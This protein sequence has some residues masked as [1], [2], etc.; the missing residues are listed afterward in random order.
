MEM[1]AQV[2]EFFSFYNKGASNQIASRGIF[3][4]HRRCFFMYLFLLILIL[5]QVLIAK[6]VVTY[7]SKF[8]VVIM[9]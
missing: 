4:M 5:K 3:I 6:T 8:Y 1:P 9:A 7:L 2:P